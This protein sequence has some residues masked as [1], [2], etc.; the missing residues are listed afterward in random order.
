[1]EP[2]SIIYGE[3]LTLPI[4]TGSVT[5]VSADIYVGK[6]GEA[7]IITKSATLVDGVGTFTF[8]PEDTRKPVG[9]YYYQ[10]NVT[11]AAGSLEKYPSPDEDCEDGTVDFPKFIIGESLDEMEVIS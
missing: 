11:P 3:S 1:M 9:T 4:D 8:L 6:P 10:I 2:I 5:D 7:Y